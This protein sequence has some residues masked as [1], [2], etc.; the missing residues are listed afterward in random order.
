MW[1][2]TSQPT[3]AYKFGDKASL[4][5]EAAFL[6]SL[7]ENPYI[8]K[9]Y[10]LRGMQH[11]ETAEGALALQLSFY[12][13]GTLAMRRPSVP[14]A[15]RMFADILRAL[16]C[17]HR[18]ELIHCDVRADNVLL[19]AE[20]DR[21]VLADWGSACTLQEAK[22]LSQPRG[23]L[24]I[25]PPEVWQQNWG[26]KVDVFAMGCL[27]VDLLGQPVSILSSMLQ[28]G[29]SASRVEH[30]GMRRFAETLLVSDPEGRPCAEAAFRE[31]CG[32]GHVMVPEAAP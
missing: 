17:A 21:A 29:R 3:L 27:V 11:P 16:I 15:V 1:R 24:T 19:E 9:S 4:L 18:C 26:P 6:R 10:G 31:L 5:R 23:A 14:E 28:S 20:T 12:G 25:V 2:R 32:G 8:V 22:L 30:A 7:P 13:G